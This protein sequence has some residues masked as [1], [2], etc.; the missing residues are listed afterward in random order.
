M[1]ILLVA[2]SLS[3]DA[4]SLALIYGINNLSKR[5]EI[6]LSLIVGLF[7]LIMPLIGYGLGEFILN[8]FPI[9]LHILVTIIFTLIGIEMVIDSLKEPKYNLLTN[10]TGMLLFGLA[11]S[12]DSFGVGIGLDILTD[13]VFSSS[14]IFMIISGLITYIGLSF[15]KIIGKKIGKISNMIGGL[16]LIIL[17]LIYMFK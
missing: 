8:L 16:I 1:I 15:G 13:N 11:V 14:V 17:G 4:F 9:E 2:L 10:I 6:I 12:I 3:M 5:K 7:H